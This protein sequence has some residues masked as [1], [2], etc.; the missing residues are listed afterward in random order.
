MDERG[1][2]LAG[3]SRAMMRA[4]HLVRRARLAA[5]AA[6]PGLEVVHLDL[7][8]ELARRPQRVSSLAEATGLEQSTVSRRISRLTGLGL[9]HKSGDEQDGRA[10]LVGLTDRGR[11]A[12][13]SLE[14]Q[15][16]ALVAREFDDWPM[17]DIATMR[18]L[19]ERLAVQLGR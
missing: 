11:K 7:L 12:V 18:L 13:A 19:L 16:I 4:A 15:R 5:P 10:H 1:A 17:E 8:G 14:E 6:V 2:E 3:L 9:V